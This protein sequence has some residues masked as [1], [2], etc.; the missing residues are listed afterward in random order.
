VGKNL[1][2]SFMKRNDNIELRKAEGLS[3]SRS[4]GWLRSYLELLC[5][6]LNVQDTS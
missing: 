3:R 2:A 1:F 6:G 4:R 5:T